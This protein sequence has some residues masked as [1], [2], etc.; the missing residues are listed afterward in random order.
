M[1]VEKTCWIQPICL[2]DEMFIERWNSIEYERANYQEE[3]NIYVTRKNE[4]VRSK[5]EVIIANMLE[6]RG[7]PYRYE[8]VLQDENGIWAMPDFTVLNVRERK[9][10]Y[11]EHFGMMEDPSYAKSAIRKIAKYEV[12]GYY[13][14]DGLIASYESLSNPLDIKQIEGLINHFLI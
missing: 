2:S 7:I 9:E 6:E 1:G 5:S 8:C 14:G 11:W 3:K 13:Q 10:Y 12:H 4:K